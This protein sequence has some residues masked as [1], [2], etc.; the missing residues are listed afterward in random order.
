M[1]SQSGVRISGPLE[2]F[3]HGFA[4]ELSELGYAPKGATFQL[5]LMA[6]L[7]RWLEREGSDASALNPPVVERFVAARRAAGYAHHRSSGALSPL[8]GYLR[9]LQAAPPAPT[10]VAVSPIEGLLYRYRRYLTAER[11]LAAGTVSNYVKLVVPFL[12]AC[13]SSAGALELEA[14]RAADVSTFVLSESRRRSPGSASTL[15]T[16]LRSLLRFLHVEG[17]LEGSLVGAV[18]SVAGWRLAGLPRPLEPGQARRLLESCDRRSANGRRDLAI[19]ML[20]ARLGL[21]AGEVAEIIIVGKGRRRERLPLP[22]DVGEALATWLHGGRPATAQGRCVF[23]R[24][25]AP[26]RRLT[27]CGV[28]QVV[29]AAG[30]RAGLGVLGPHRLRHTAATEMLRAGAS[31]EEIGQ[32]LRHRRLGSTAIYAKVDHDALR[33]LARPWP[34]GGVA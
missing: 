6:H 34:T 31:L 27:A 3:A 24:V 7:S 16:A 29:S 14:L 20:L 15:V 23:T 28:G 25:R 21:R 19:V 32:V 26:H 10:P 4:V 11:G 5:R 18:P 33:P 30:R 13:E 17:V 9:R 22:G 2:P 12:V 8:L 1:V